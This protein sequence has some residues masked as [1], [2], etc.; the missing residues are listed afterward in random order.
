M[1]IFAAVGLVIGLVNLAFSLFDLRVLPIIG[2]LSFIVSM[3]FFYAYA[4][5]RE[6]KY[7]NFASL[8]LFGYVV[9]SMIRLFT[10]KG[11]F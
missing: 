4:S 8:F 6:K 9:V 3:A 11:Y 10:E 7:V 2:A 1:K 5:R